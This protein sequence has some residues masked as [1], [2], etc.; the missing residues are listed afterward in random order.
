M[1]QTAA[2]EVRNVTKSIAGKTIVKDLS[3]TVQAG[4]I[5]G[6][7]GPN[8]A[9]KTTTI[10]MMVGL[11]S[12]G[13][14]DI[15]IGGSSIRS[16]RGKALEQIGAIVENPELYKEMSGRQNL[17]H[18]ANMSSKPVSKKRME[19]VIRLVQL[20]EAIDRK[21]KTYSLGMRQRLGVAQ[22]ILHRPSILI[23]DEPTNG[24]DPAGIRQLRQYLQQ[25]A[26]TEG[27][28]VVVS[29]HLIA[30][31]E[32]LCDRVIIIQKGQLVAE[33]SLKEMDEDGKVTV[34]I[35][36]TDPERASLLLKPRFN[37]ESDGG[38]VISI[39]AKREDLP[40]LVSDLV[41]H[42]IGIVQVK[43]RTAKL[44]DLF[45]QLTQGVR[46]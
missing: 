38:N 29:S 5:Y 22:A 17:K 41:Q 11:I 30:E 16:A 24:L 9:G 42:G 23:L 13:K 26:K 37:G 19:E 45:L 15:R 28:A 39:R 35:E 4:E 34:D 36:V 3:F 1:S 18:Y 10:R 40:G 27:M 6:F 25:L 12:I 21:V 8:G 32:L 20:D 7:L 2:I 43:I 33:R 14:G 46:S 31:I 44:E